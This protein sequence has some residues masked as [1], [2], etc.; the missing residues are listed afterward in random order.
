[1]RRKM[2][3][4]RNIW[5]KTQGYAWKVCGLLNWSFFEQK[6]R[7]RSLVTAYGSLSSI[8]LDIGTLTLYDESDNHACQELLAKTGV[9]SNFLRAMPHLQCLKLRFQ[10][11]YECEPVLKDLPE[12]GIHK[13]AA[14]LEHII[15]TSFTWPNLRKLWLAGVDMQEDL[16]FEVLLRHKD[17]L[18]HLELEKCALQ[19]SWVRLLPKIQKT[20]TLSLGYLYGLTKAYGRTPEEDEEWAIRHFDDDEEEDVFDPFR[21]ALSAWFKE[22]GNCPLSKENIT[23]RRCGWTSFLDPSDE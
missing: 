11:L 12:D 19:G 14:R 5:I 2:L 9:L 13:Y 3:I 4:W 23:S 18:R 6:A 21:Q 20:S 7:L 17:T 10:P 1:M 15:P 22:G 8:H 16:L